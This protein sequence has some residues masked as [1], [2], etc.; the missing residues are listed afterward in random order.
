MWADATRRVGL[1]S[2]RRTR[3][4]LAQFPWLVLLCVPEAIAVVLAVLSH[5][6]RIAHESAKV[7]LK[8]RGDAVVRTVVCCAVSPCFLFGCRAAGLTRRHA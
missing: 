4:P 3:T 7:S 8:A 2:Q 6:V 1:C 5:V